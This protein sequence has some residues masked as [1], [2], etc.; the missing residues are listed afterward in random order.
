[1]T[2]SRRLLPVLATAAL[3]ATAAPARAQSGAGDD[4]YTD[5]FGT[6]AKKSQKRSSTSKK[7][8]KS[9][10]SGPPLSNKPPVS[11]PSTT[12][13]TTTAPVATGQL[14]RT[15]FEIPG[16]ALLGAGLLASGIGLRLRTVDDTIF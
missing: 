11:T 10:A 6:T 5:P 2:A 1:M 3:V 13:T 4:Q 8:S 12:T 14:P 16:V 7:A 15:G 9:Q